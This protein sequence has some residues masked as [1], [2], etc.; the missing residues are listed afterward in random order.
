MRERVFVRKQSGAALCLCFGAFCT[1]QTASELAD[2]NRRHR[3]DNRMIT[4]DKIHPVQMTCT[5]NMYRRK[6]EIMKYHP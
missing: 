5:A 6:R 1:K 3:D 2:N 4:R